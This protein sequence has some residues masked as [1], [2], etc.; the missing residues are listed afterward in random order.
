MIETRAGLAEADAIA[1][2]DGVDFVFI[3]TGDL[4]LSLGEFPQVGKAHAGACAAILTACRRANK[5][6]GAFALSPAIAK[7][8]V[9][10]GFALVTVGND[11]DIA[12]S[13]FAA[14]A[15]L[16]KSNP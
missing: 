6:C 1:A 10:D 15:R 7:A 5:P 16:L 12:R 9:A 11:L 3:G 13:G 2:V 8:F 14:A 4:A